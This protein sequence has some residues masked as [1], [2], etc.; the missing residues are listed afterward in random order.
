V[1]AEL[2]D[3]V[4]AGADARKLERYDHFLAGWALHTRRYG[5][6]AQA[7][8]LV[9]FVCRDRSRARRCAERADVVLRACRAYAG[10][11]PSEWQYPGRERVR[12]VSERDV[13]EGLLVA[14]RVPPLPPDVRASASGGDPRDASA[15]A[16]PCSL[17]DAGVGADACAVASDDGPR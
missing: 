12:F 15:C 10:E 13:H 2:D 14:L 6:R 7:I 5:A 4:P 11:Y 17:L 3:R 1:I 9:V 16:L 8:A